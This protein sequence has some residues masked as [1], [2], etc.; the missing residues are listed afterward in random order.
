MYKSKEP[1]AVN[2][3]ASPELIAKWGKGKTLRPP[4]TTV[5]SRPHPTLTLPQLAHRGPSTNVAAEPVP[6]PMKAARGD[7]DLMSKPQSPQSKE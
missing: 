2:G 5:E 3:S 6:A 7:D 4:F 1:P